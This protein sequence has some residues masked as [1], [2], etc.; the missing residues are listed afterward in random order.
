M[1]DLKWWGELGREGKLILNSGQHWFLCSNGSWSVEVKVVFNAW[2]RPTAGPSNECQSTFILIPF[3]PKPSVYGAGCTANSRPLKEPR[4]PWVYIFGR[5]P[6][7]DLPT[8]PVNMW[9]GHCIQNLHFDTIWS[10]VVCCPLWSPHRDKS[11]MRRQDC[12]W[13]TDSKGCQKGAPCLLR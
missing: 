13:C 12:S 10:L 2:A 5:F 8:Q 11:L 3:L 7:V 6:T 4:A 9:G 1:Q